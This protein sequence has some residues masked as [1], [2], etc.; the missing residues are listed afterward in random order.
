MFFML[1]ETEREVAA[2]EF[3]GLAARSPYIEAMAFHAVSLAD[4]SFLF[5]GWAPYYDQ[6][7]LKGAAVAAN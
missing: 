2:L 4:N 5:S 6:F 3:T 1:Y 7:E